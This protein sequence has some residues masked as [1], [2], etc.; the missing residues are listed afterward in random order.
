MA[1]LLLF[2]PARMTAAASSDLVGGATVDE[3]LREACARYGEAFGALLPR[4]Q[5]WVNGDPCEAGQPVTDRDEVAIL[6][7]VSGG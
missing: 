3:V 4:C 6:P 2:G 7:P 1:R 5:V